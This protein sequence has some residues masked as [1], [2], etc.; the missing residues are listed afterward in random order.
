MVSNLYAATEATR[1]IRACGRAPEVTVDSGQRDPILAGKKVCQSKGPTW[2]R[3]LTSWQIGPTRR[4]D[5]QR[6]AGVS[7]NRLVDGAYPPVRGWR[8]RSRL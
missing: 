4:R 5:T 7:G 8:G 1:R 6:G 3:V 2:R